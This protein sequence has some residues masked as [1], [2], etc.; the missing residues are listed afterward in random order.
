MD[1]EVPSPKIEPRFGVLRI[2][3]LK[4]LVQCRPGI[5]LRF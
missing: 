1:G 3:W 4:R 2:Q 5:L